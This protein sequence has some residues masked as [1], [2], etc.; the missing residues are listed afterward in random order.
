[1][2]QLEKNITK[3]FGRVRFDIVKLQEQILKLTENQARIMEDISKRKGSVK[4]TKIV[5][6][7][8]A[9]HFVASKTGKKFH[10]PECIFTKN[11]KPKSR[12]IFKSKTTALNAG[13]KPCDC[14]K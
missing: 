9:K 11:I 4:I 3:S 8:K 7:S 2:D 10:I 6:R 13:Y 12:V 1:M 5:E 14:T